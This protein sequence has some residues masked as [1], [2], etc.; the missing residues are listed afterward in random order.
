MSHNLAERSMATTI[1]LRRETKARPDTEKVHP[2]ES[3]DDVGGRLPD[4]A[5][6][7]EPL[8]EET[9]QRIEESIA[10]MRAGQCRPFEEVFGNWN[11]RPAIALGATAGDTI[12]FHE[13]Q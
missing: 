7:P 3:Y 4:A 10:D 2:Q 6:D 5:Y 11:R 13:N 9:L 1:R 12:T 8:S